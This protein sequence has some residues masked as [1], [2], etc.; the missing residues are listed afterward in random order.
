MQYSLM[1]TFYITE[2]KLWK[3][4]KAINKK[5]FR[6][7]IWLSNVKITDYSFRPTENIE[8]QNASKTQSRLYINFFDIYI[9]LWN[10]TYE[11]KH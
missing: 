5:S 2:E 10:T 4:A 7:F 8:R 1:F 6:T 3:V 11:R 9:I